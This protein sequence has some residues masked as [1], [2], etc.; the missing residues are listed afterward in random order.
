VFCLQWGIGLTIDALGAIGWTR[1]ASFQ[2]AMGLLALGCALAQAWFLY[3]QRRI[4][5]M[6]GQ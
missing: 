3:W 4:V 5:I 6:P 1:V 2:A